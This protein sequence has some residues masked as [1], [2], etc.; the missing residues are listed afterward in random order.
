[1][2]G[3][4]KY[5]SSDNYVL[6]GGGGDKPVSDFML[7]NNGH[8]YVEI[9]GLKWATMNIGASQPSDYG[10]YFAWGD[11]QGYTAAQVGSGEGQKY[12]G[13]ADCKYNSGGTSPSAADMTKY[14]STDSKTVLEESD[15][16]AQVN[17]GGQWRMPTTAEFV[18][19]GAAT[20]NAWVTDYQGSGVNGRLFTDNTDSSKKL[21]FPAAGR[22]RDG[23]VGYVGSYG[24]YWSSSLNTSDVVIGRLLRF[25]SGS[26]YINDDYRRNG[27]AVRG[28]VD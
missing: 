9:G 17:W 2:G 14:N 11:T 13:W 4:N 23:S 8:D 3:F 5:G 7:G 16:V 25:L 26:C 15:D 28:V 19:L 6:L 21:F 18:A 24:F 27:F 1:M 22:C 12:F 20:T 10:L